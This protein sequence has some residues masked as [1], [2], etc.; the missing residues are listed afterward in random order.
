MRC[1][2][3]NITKIRENKKMKK[4][5]AL[6]LTVIM[7]CTALTACGGKDTPA[8]APSSEPSAQSKP[9]DEEDYTDVEKSGIT[10]EEYEE[11]MSGF[12][13]SF[14]ELCGKIGE[15]LALSESISSEDDLIAWAQA[16]ITIKD[17][18]GVAA[19]KLAEVTAEVPEEYQESHVQITIAV[20]AVY[21][22]MTGFENA[23]DAVLNGDVAAYEDGLVEF[24]GNM[25]AADALW[26]EA[27]VY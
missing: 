23:V 12:I 7:L 3:N 17:G 8:D 18:I 5:L 19:D 26:D 10:P 24:I 22:G 25:A 21:D 14:E 9:A 11:E 6:L 1:G 16:F 2:V 27:I 20:A 13:A 4:L 15:L